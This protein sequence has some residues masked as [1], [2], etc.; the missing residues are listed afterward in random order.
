MKLTLTQAATI[1]VGDMEAHRGKECKKQDPLEMMKKADG[2]QREQ[3][4]SWPR[5]FPVQTSRV[6]EARYD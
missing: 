1:L 3:R 2:M 5:L 4:L 6:L